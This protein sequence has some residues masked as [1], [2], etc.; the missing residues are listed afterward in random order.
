M[1]TIEK[2]RAIEL[3]IGGKS[4]NEISKQLGVARSSVSLWVRDI[5]LTTDQKNYL[6]RKGL[7]VEVVERRRATRLKNEKYKR[8]AVINAARKTIPKIT[9]KQLWLIGIMLYWAEGGKTHKLVRFSN[10]DPR[11]IKIMMKFFREICNVPEQKFRGYIHIHQHLDHVSA[12]HYWSLIS[13]IPTNKFYKTYRKPNK[14]SL[15]KRDTLPY[16]TFD[17]YVLDT[18][19][20]YKIIG[21][22][23]GIFLKY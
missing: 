3:R 7:L 14:S 12:E 22:S 20:F 11:M 17:I 19:L 10:S 18:N 2:R 4:I 6:S 13:G 16:G 1:K 9:N 23:E 15:G 5:E 8:D 21:W